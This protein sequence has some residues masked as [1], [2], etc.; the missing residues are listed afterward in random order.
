[1]DVEVSVD[2]QKT[3]WLDL[4]EPAAPEI[5][6]GNQTLDS[7]QGLQEQEHLESVHGVEKRPNALGDRAALIEESEFFLLRIVEG[8]PTR[9]VRRWKVVEDSVEVG[10]VEEAIDD[11]V[12]KRVRAA[13]GL[14]IRPAVDM[15]RYRAHCVSP[16]AKSTNTSSL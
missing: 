9:A 13:V 4:M 6:V 14:R 16:F 5:R 7:G 15:Q 2:F 10:G 12:R 11:G 1:M 8:H 3:A